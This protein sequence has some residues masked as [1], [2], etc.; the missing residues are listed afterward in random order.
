MKYTVIAPFLVVLFT[1]TKHAV[2]TAA[3][4]GVAPT[5]INELVENEEGEVVTVEFTSAPT[6]ADP[7]GEGDD[8][9]EVMDEDENEDGDRA[10][11]VPPNSIDELGEYEEKEPLIVQ[12]TS[13]P[14]PANPRGEG[15]DED[16]DEEQYEYGDGNKDVPSNE[17]GQYL[18]VAVTSA[19]TPDHPRGEGDKDDQENEYGDGYDAD[20]EADFNVDEDGGEDEY[21]DEDEDADEEED[22]NVGGEGNGDAD[23]DKY[24][25]EDEG[26]G[27]D[28]D[29][30]KDEDEE[31]IEN[32]SSPTLIPEP[33]PPGDF[34]S[35]PTYRPTSKHGDEIYSDPYS[36][37][38]S[39]GIS[40]PSFSTKPPTLK[41]TV[42]YIPIRG[43]DAL[44]EEIEPDVADFDDDGTFYHGLGGKLGKVGD[45]LDG[46]ESPQKLEKDRNVQIVAGFLVV[47]SLVFLLVTAH[48]VMQYPDGLC[49]GF[50]RLTLKCICCF[51]RTLCLP[52]RA[53]CC[54]GSDQAHS[55]RTHAP[56]RTPFPTDLELA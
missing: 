38:N 49:A 6:L 39:E 18:T 25:N 13:A 23:E 28:D 48:M 24:A 9:D 43:N 1:L 45:Y 30:D 34:G 33:L 12:V 37:K 2:A 15:G 16:E 53:I 56:M 22:E 44:A 40:R 5:P 19:P 54:K 42:E 3:P 8:D 26:D 21:G 14:T 55:R 46:V 36:G 41:P 50:C 27:E 29:E 17:E 20:G 35:D 31:S 52:C 10:E 7:R 32:T 51:M 47:V 11:D 4:T